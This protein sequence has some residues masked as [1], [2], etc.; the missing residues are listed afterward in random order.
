MWRLAEGQFCK[1]ETFTDESACLHW[2][3]WDMHFHAIL[4]L[5]QLEFSQVPAMLVEGKGSP[6]QLQTAWKHIGDV[7]ARQGCWQQVEHS[8]SKSH[9]GLRAPY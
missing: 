5:M 4:T 3:H 9:R 6:E 1:P 2:A 8:F 7:F